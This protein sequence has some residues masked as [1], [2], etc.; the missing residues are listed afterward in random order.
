MEKDMRESPP[1][2]EEKHGE[3]CRQYNLNQSIE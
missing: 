3:Y 1:S 2:R